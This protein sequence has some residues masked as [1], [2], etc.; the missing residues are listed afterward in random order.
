MTP[1]NEELFLTSFEF[2]SIETQFSDSWNETN[3][4]PPYVMGYG[5]PS[6]NNVMGS[7]STDEENGM[8]SYSPFTQ[9][10]YHVPYQMQRG[11][12]PS[13]WMNL[14]YPIHVKWVSNYKILCAYFKICMVRGDGDGNPQAFEP[15]SAIQQHVLQHS[16][17]LRKIE[18]EL[19]LF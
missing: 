7:S 13:T 3:V 18:A 11:F 19:G 9:M 17:I 2:M 4:Y 12:D 14:K 1:F 10:S 15:E 5:Q 6:Q 16:H 8:S